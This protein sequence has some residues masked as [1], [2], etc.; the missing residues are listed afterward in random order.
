MINKIIIFI[1]LTTSTFSFSDPLNNVQCREDIW[2]QKTLSSPLSCTASSILV[3]G[4]YRYKPENLFDKNMH[5]CWCPKQGKKGN[6]IDEFVIM[7][8]PYGI[9]GIRIR[10]GFVKSK[11]LFYENNRVKKIFLAWL[12][13]RN[14][15]SNLDKRY[16]TCTYEANGK[17]K[18]RKYNLTF[19]SGYKKLIILEDSK[20]LQEILFSKVEDFNWNDDHFKKNRMNKI[21]LLIGILEVYRGTK[22]N[23]TCITE[24]EIIK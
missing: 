17:Y 20:A 14:H 18:N 11:K 12:T 22:Y 15:Q 3:E 5:T 16:S 2:I 9:K 1:I 8:I 19:H 23:D 24:I 7:Q 21:Y 6:G 10:N 4:N 13:T